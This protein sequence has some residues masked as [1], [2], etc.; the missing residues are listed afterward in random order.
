MKKERPCHSGAYCAV[1]SSSG[2]DG[3]ELLAQDV[4]RSGELG[5]DVTRLDL[6][7]ERRGPT[8]PALGEPNEVVR[9]LVLVPSPESVCFGGQ[10]GCRSC[11]S[12][13]L[14]CSSAAVRQVA[15]ELDDPEVLIDRAPVAR[16]QVFIVIVSVR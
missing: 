5:E 13:L 4:E 2:V 12:E 7:R 10:L 6:G 11:D 3:R 15:L 8:G 16:A 9:V 14:L 1:H